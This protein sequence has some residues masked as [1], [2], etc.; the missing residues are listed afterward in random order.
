MVE[1]ILMPP[2]TR[3]NGSPE[4]D[5]PIA[6]LRALRAELWRNFWSTAGLLIVNWLT[7]MVWVVLLL[8]SASPSLVIDD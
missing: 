6:E 7:L 1:S 2:T 5:S 8:R 4:H 3:L